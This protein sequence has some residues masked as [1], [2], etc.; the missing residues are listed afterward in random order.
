MRREET[1]DF[2]IKSSWHAIARMYNQKATQEANLTS[3]IGFVLININSKEGTPATKIAPL[4]GLESRSLTRMLKGMEEKGLIFRQPDATDK[5]S[6]RIFLTQKGVR[7]KGL[8]VKTINEFNELVRRELSEDELHIF[9]RVFKKIN[10]V[11][12]EFS[13]GSKMDQLDPK[14]GNEDE[15]PY[16]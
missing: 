10:G 7:L 6:V 13:S 4:M 5:R 3:S 11:I 9:F 2:H 15:F 12:E 16:G 8:S 1:I 14:I